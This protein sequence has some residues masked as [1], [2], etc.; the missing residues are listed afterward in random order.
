VLASRNEQK[1]YILVPIEYVTKWVEV[2]ATKQRLQ[3]WCLNFYLDILLVDL[4]APSKNW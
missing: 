2:Q 3:K 1:K 4:G